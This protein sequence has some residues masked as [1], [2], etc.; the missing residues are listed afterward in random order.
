MQL[1]TED[2][3]DKLVKWGLQLGLSVSGLCARGGVTE[4]FILGISCNRIN[5]F[6]AYCNIASVSL[7]PVRCYPREVPHLKKTVIKVKISFVYDEEQRNYLRP[8]N[9]I[10]MLIMPLQCCGI[11]GKSKCQPAHFSA[12]A[13]LFS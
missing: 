2:E 3:F 5:V 10:R 8:E 7:I 13:Q 11:Q 6:A 9:Y 4:D 12:Q 1:L